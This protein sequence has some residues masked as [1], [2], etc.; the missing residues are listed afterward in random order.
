MIDV[1]CQITEVTYIQQVRLGQPVKTVE[2]GSLRATVQVECLVEVIND[3]VSSDNPQEK[4]KRFPQALHEVFAF[5]RSKKH[6]IQRPLG[7]LE[8][9]PF[10]Q[11]RAAEVMRNMPVLST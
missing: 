7:R 2:V 1:F 11:Y 8:P 3:L 5:G 6:M 10:L 4:L 9:T